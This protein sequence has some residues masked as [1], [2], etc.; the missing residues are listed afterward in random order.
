MDDKVYLV[1]KDGRSKGGKD[2]PWLLNY[3]PSGCHEIM[4]NGK[5]QVV[6]TCLWGDNRRDAK[7]F[8]DEAEANRVA[9]SAGNCVVISAKRGL[10]E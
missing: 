10:P 8:L 9:A 2:S 3:K 1:K 6:Y 7:I 4:A 5:R